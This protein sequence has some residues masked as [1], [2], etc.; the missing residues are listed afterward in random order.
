MRQSVESIY[1]YYFQ[2]IYRFLLSLCNSHHTAEDLVQETFLRAYL[3]VDENKTGSIKTW[4]FTVAYH[5]FIDYYRKQKRIELKGDR[6]LR[7]F[8]D[9]KQTPEETVMIDEEIQLIVNQM[10]QLAEKQK[11]AILLHDFH[12][13]TYKEAAAVMDVSLASFKVSLFR[14]RQVIRKQKELE[15][16]E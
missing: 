1:S 11:L 7:G 13:L 14:G 4:L 2:D 3:H 6:F 5:A 10:G 16:N 15:K 8:F 9:K 12:Q